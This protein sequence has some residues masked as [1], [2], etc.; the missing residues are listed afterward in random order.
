M[1]A[2]NWRTMR[3]ERHPQYWVKGT[4]LAAATFGP[5]RRFM[6]VAYRIYMDAERLE[7]D[8]RF[9]VRDAHKVS[10]EQL[11]AGGRSPIVGDFATEDEAIAFC[12]AATD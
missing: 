6:I 10:D 12:R 1:I 2:L 4:E 7:P 3:G 5:H 8:R 11:R 9:R